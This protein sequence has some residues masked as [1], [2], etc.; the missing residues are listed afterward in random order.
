M[1]NFFFF[2]TLDLF[3]ANKNPENHCYFITNIL[4]YHILY[5]LYTDNWHFF[6]PNLDY[7][8]RIC[9]IKKNALDPIINF[10]EAKIAAKKRN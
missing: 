6:L 5:A 4:W 2:E 8:L 7:F 9:Q 3:F 1:N 10:K